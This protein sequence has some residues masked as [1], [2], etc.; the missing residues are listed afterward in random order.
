MNYHYR[1]VT[2]TTWQKHYHHPTVGNILFL[3]G[4]CYFSAS[5][6][7]FFV[8]FSM[9]AF[10]GASRKQQICQ[11]RVA[12]TTNW[13]LRVTKAKLQTRKLKT[14][15]FLLQGMT[16]SSRSSLSKEISADAAHQRVRSSRVRSTGPRLRHG[17]NP[18]DLPLGVRGVSQ[19]RSGGRT[20][21]KWLCGEVA[22]AP[23]RGRG[24]GFFSCSL[25]G[26]CVRLHPLVQTH[27]IKRAHTHTLTHTSAPSR[28]HLVDI[29][30]Q[31]S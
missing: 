24:C 26:V 1:K 12:V 20:V 13:L 22:S 27:A 14:S 31:S 10:T 6:R 5:D 11:R 23:L 3:P 9:L 28:C 7:F 18:T 15:W 2:K 19:R 8:C 25:L 29:F 4:C 17:V 30:I 16:G 21:Q